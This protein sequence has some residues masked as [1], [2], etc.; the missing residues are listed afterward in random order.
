MVNKGN[1]DNNDKNE[2]YYVNRKYY[3][4][5]KGGRYNKKGRYNNNNKRLAR[6]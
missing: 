5:D 6:T 3:R 1:D 4:N 2:A